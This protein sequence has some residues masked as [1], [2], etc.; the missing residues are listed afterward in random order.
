[1]KI[2]NFNF[3][4]TAFAEIPIV[5]D[6]RWKAVIVLLAIL[7]GIVVPPSLPF[8]TATG[9]EASLGTLDVC[10]KAAPALSSH[11]DMPCMN[12]C[13]CQP[14]PL[15]SCAVPDTL[16]SAF[17]PLLLPFQDERPPQA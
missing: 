2:S 5:E 14:L 7:I 9:A 16:S 1:M 3:T 4:L 17:K 10:H 12:E 8:L 6:M 11:G 15:A 13:P